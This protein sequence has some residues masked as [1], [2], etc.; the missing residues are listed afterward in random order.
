MSERILI[1]GEPGSGKSASLR[2]LP[3]EQTYYIDADGKG[4][5]WKNWRDEYSTEKHNY[6]RTDDHDKIQALIDN[7]AEKGTNIHYIVVDT[8]NAVMLRDE[9]DRSKGKGF[10]KWLDLATCVYEMIRKAST[11]RDDLTIIFLGHTQTDRDDNGY[12]FTRMKTSGR[13]LDKICLESLFNTV[14]MTKATEDGYVFELHANNSTVRTPM[15]AFEEN[16][17]PNDIT[18]VL[19][20]LKEY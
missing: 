18:T 20:V 15:G 4:L 10:D 8:L 5:P 3:P 2:N 13:K 6:T 1:L 9:F 19:N 17:I 16:T 11:Y 7:I 14:I 12:M